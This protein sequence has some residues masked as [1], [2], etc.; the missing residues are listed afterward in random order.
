MQQSVAGQRICLDKLNTPGIAREREGC[1]VW[2]SSLYLKLRVRAQDIWYWWLCA[3]GIIPAMR[4]GMM[5]GFVCNLSFLA[6][7]GPAVCFCWTPAAFWALTLLFLPRFV[8]A[9][10]RQQ[11]PSCKQRAACRQSLPPHQQLQTH[12][13]LL[14]VVPCKSTALN[15][16]DKA[17]DL[18]SWHPEFRCPVSSNERSSCH[19]NSQRSEAKWVSCCFAV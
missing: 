18:Q 1:S 15:V 4:S 8:F 3:I 6:V 10:M 17:S 7:L 14:L 5:G 16:T 11:D 9:S 12:Y 2:V 13:S 19:R